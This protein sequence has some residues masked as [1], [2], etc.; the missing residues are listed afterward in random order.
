MISTFRRFGSLAV[1]EFSTADLTYNRDKSNTDTV[2]ASSR[3][4]PGSRTIRL[5]LTQYSTYMFSGH[6]EVIK[7]E[8]MKCIHLNNTVLMYRS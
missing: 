6:Q 3:V 2:N 5:R 7:A 8:S 4:T 1:Q